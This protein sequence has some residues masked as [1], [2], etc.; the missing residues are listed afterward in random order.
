VRLAAVDSLRSGNAADADALLLQA[1]G[2]SDWE[3]VERAAAAL[4]ERGAGPDAAKALSKVAL[5][6]PARRTRILA[7]RALAKLPG[8]ADAAEALTRVRP[9]DYAVALDSVGAVGWTRESEALVKF[10]ERGLSLRKD[11]KA[12]AAAAGAIGVYAAA[13]RVAKL[14]ALT[15]LPDAA[16]SAAAVDAVRAKPDD[17]YLPALVEILARR[18][19]SSARRGARGWRSSRRR[20]GSRRAT[21]RRRRRRSSRTR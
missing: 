19:P 10:V 16:V 18:R 12:Q 1:L 11:E 21:R 17:A 2:D 9:D 8:W 20:R 13:D 4:G 3:V 7:A 5:G 6:A 15:A 14:R